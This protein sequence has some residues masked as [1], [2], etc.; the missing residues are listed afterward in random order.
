MVPGSC[1]LWRRGTSWSGSTARL[2]PS[3]LLSQA[4]SLLSV[5]SPAPGL[6]IFTGHL[7]PRW[8]V[9]GEQLQAYILVSP[10][11]GP[12]ARAQPGGGGWDGTVLTGVL[13]SDP[14]GAVE[15]A[16]SPGCALAI[17]QD[18][19][20]GQ[21]EGLG[22]RRMT[23]RRQLA[24]CQDGAEEGW[25]RPGATAGTQ[26]GHPAVVLVAL[27]GPHISAA[28]LPSPCQ[29][30]GRCFLQ[31]PEAQQPTASHASFLWCVHSV[32]VSG[33][34]EHVPGHPVSMGT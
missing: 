7:V 26:R 13:L 10:A 29:R 5:L 4:L 8:Q 6:P 20:Q 28:R 18:V 22:G 16:W 30:T 21:R 17:P 33:H 34:W 25:G 14:E 12:G 1:H 24:E 32:I 19:Q 15:P 27:S 31:S 23:P 9:S 3:T 2:Q 11:L